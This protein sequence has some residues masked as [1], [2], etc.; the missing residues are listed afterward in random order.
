MPTMKVRIPF[1]GKNTAPPSCS[2]LIADDSE[3][4]RSRLSELAQRIPGV[5]AVHAAANASQAL[6]LANQHHPAII[7]V[8]V[9][10]DQAY[11]GL[12]GQ[13]KQDLPDSILIALLRTQP[14][15]GFPPVF[16]QQVDDFFDRSTNLD[17]IFTFLKNHVRQRISG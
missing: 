6:D 15:A 9:H 7:L 8:D 10:I 5:D 14:I 3:T 11:G 17:Q 1:W 13:I 2:I 16:P 4:F 12:F